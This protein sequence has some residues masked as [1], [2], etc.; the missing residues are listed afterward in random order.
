MNYLKYKLLIWSVLVACLT[1]NAQ[2]FDK[3]YTEEFITNSDVL[4]DVDTRHTDIKIESWNKNKVIVEAQIEIEGADEQ[5]TNEIIENWKFKA[6]GNK[7][8]VE[9]ISK[10]NRFYPAAIG[11]A[12]IFSENYFDKHA[13]PEDFEIVIPDISIE[14]LAILDSLHVVMPPDALHFPEIPSVPE[15]DFNYNFSFEA[16]HFDYEKYKKDENY[17]KEWQEEMKVQL[18]EMKI[19][20]K[21]NSFKIQENNAKLKEELK[22]A[23][24]ERRKEY[25]KLR[26][27]R[28]KKI[29]EF[30]KLRTEKRKEAAKVRKEIMEQRRKELAERRVKVK[31]ILEERD[32]IKIKRTIVI[33]APKNAKFNM[34]VKYGTISFDN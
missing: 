7:K 20:L 15:M 14:N 28:N 34:N 32:K 1:V 21:E 2:K 26:E 5:K 9:V 29:V 12:L 30:E 16:P 27:E 4:I 18:E 23:Q 8:E 6:L 25:E 13:I 19:E 33:K 17:L 22:A 24:E 11:E 31:K 10:V 3:T